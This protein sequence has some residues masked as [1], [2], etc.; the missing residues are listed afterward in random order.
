MRRGSAE[1]ADAML[2][3]SRDDDTLAARARASVFRPRARREGRERGRVLTRSTT[4]ED[5]TRVPSD[6]M[7][8]PSA[9]V[10]RRASV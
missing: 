4:R 3:R 9:C 5:R 2:A 10:W 6:A 8:R 7:R 1:E